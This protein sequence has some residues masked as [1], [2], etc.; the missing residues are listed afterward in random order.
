MVNTTVY[1][2]FISTDFRE[3]F[4]LIINHMG[5]RMRPKGVLML[6]VH[7][8]NHILYDKLNCKM[9]IINKNISQFF[10]HIDAPT[11]VACEFC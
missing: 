5:T 3:V 1:T 8:K 2:G 4:G 7:R 10:M 9:M 11:F 6:G